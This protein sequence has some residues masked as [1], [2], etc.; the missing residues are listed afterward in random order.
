MDRVKEIAQ[1]VL[2]NNKILIGAFLTMVLSIPIGS[3]TV[4]LALKTRA[5]TADTSQYDRTV[6]L[7]SPVPQASAPQTLKD[8]LEALTEELK[9]NA[10]KKEETA[11][12]DIATPTISFGPTLDFKV[13]LEGRPK[14]KQG[15]KMF[16]GI[17]SGDPTNKPTYLLSFNVDV[18]SDGSYSGL[19]L[20]GLNQGDRYTAYLKS[21]AQIAT[22]SAFLVGP[23]KTT[24]NAGE[25]VNL[26]TGDL[27]E[28]NTIN[29]LDYAIAKAVFNTTPKSDKWNSNVDFNLDD[30]INLFDLGIILKN[31]GK[32]GLSG[33]WQS[34]PIASGS[35]ALNPSVAG[36]N[37]GNPQG[38]KVPEKELELLKKPMIVPGMGGQWVWVPR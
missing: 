29:T 32:T 26:I 17:A 8:N 30:V 15:T 18:K 28:D 37:T 31:W 7:S 1:L 25:A 34:T 13:A 21:P 9:E 11:E 12:Q 3:Y 27:N 22:S 24:L 35:A 6:T 36:I 10:D 5:S 38:G 33:T 19:S 23:T 2:A 14:D 16:V 20:A 4:S